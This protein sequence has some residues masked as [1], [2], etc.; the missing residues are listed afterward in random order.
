MS[1]GDVDVGAR[2]ALDI[3]QVSPCLLPVLCWLSEALNLCWLDHQAH[4][5]DELS[6][7][8]GPLL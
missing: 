5:S 3:G 2:Y 7:A 8:W 1:R 4:S 6:A